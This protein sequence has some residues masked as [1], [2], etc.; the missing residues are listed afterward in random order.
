MSH[1]FT[2]AKKKAVMPV[3]QMKSVRVD[4][5]TV[6]LVDARIS[7]AEAIQHYAEKRM[8]YMACRQGTP[9]YPEKKEFKEVPVGEIAELEAILDKE[10]LPE[11]E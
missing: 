5:R 4:G 2:P 11:M 9:N 6:I 8:L 3:R 1:T 10:N 7:N